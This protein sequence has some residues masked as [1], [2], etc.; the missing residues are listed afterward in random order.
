MQ[1]DSATGHA[2]SATGQ[3]SPTNSRFRS[4]PQAQTCFQTACRQFET[5]VRKD[6]LARVDYELVRIPRVATSR[7][8]L[9]AFVCRAAINVNSSSFVIASVFGVVAPTVSII[10]VIIIIIVV[11]S[12]PLIIVM[13]A[14]G[15]A[16]DTVLY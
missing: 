5:M 15:H 9:C 14:A 16:L 7:N 12:I 2:S 1:I 13:S 6:A 3:M 11:I 8:V 4:R 10:I